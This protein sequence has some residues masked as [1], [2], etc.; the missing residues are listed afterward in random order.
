MV[1]IN[2][3]GTS[4]IVAIFG[5]QIFL[6]PFRAA[7]DLNCFH[8]GV[9]VPQG[10]PCRTG[11]GDPGDKHLAY[12]S[13][14]QDE[15]EYH[16]SFNGTINLSRLWSCLGSLTC[17]QSTGPTIVKSVLKSCRPLRFGN[18]LALKLLHRN[19]TKQAVKS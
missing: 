18:D 10:R 2:F 11:F 6:D 9:S 12:H 19:P 8:E 13:F 7:V 1:Y 3:W 5:H 14:R 4:S 16:G 15:D 17:P